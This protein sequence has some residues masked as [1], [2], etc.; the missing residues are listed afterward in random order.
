[1]GRNE[2][3]YRC[4]ATPCRNLHALRIGVAGSPAPRLR[5]AIR[6]LLSRSRRAGVHLVGGRPAERCLVATC[7]NLRD[8]YYYLAVLYG[9]HLIKLRSI[10]FFPRMRPVADAGVSVRPSSWQTMARRRPWPPG[11]GPPAYRPFRHAMSAPQTAAAPAPARLLAP[12]LAAVPALRCF[13]CNERCSPAPPR[14]ELPNNALHPPVA[15]LAAAALFLLPL[16]RVSPTPTPQGR[17]LP[18]PLGPAVRHP[19]AGSVP[20]L[21]DQGASCRGCSCRDAWQ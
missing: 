8:I 17:A 13:P 12:P 14:R 2:L 16:Q 10:D 1:M 21:V 5:R 7:L 19:A 15:A 18:V 9:E 6:V 20:T 3:A 4:D 11:E